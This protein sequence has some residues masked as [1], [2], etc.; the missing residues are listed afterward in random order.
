MRWGGLMKS[1]LMG[2]VACVA[3]VLGNAFAYHQHVAIGFTLIGIGG[4]MVGMLASKA[5]K[6]DE[7]LDY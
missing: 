2:P 5:A 4:L 3:I 1:M 6:W 7:S